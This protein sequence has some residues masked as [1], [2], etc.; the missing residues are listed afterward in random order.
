MNKMY[1]KMVVREYKSTDPYQ[2]K[3]VES[4]TDHELK[5]K[6]CGYGCERCEILDACRIGKEWAKRMKEAEK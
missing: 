6:L 2:R 4:Y 5:M 1:G 3:T